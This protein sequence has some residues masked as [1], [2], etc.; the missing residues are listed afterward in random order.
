NEDLSWEELSEANIRMLRDME[1]HSWAKIRIDMIQNFW[2]EIESHRWH[3]STNESNK[4]ALLVFQGRNACIGTPTAF[5]LIPISDQQIHEYCDELIDHAKSLEIVKLQQ[6]HSL[7]SAIIAFSSTALNV[8]PF[9]FLSFFFP[10]HISPTTSYS[11]LPPWEPHFCH[12]VV[13]TLGF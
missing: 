12:P 8:P 5:N 10:V 9:L 2:I 6:V 7:T 3:H 13:L 11:F 1:C 4:H